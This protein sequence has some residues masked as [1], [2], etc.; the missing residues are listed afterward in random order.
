MKS[1]SEIIK[2]CFE[3]YKH[4]QGMVWTCGLSSLCPLCQFQ[5]NQLNEFEE[6]IN[7][8]I[9]IIG[10]AWENYNV[11][12]VLQELLNKLNGVDNHSH[13][14]KAKLYFTKFNSDFSGSDKQLNNTGDKNENTNT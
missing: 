9:N 11:V 6:M 10:N 12:E 3:V 7:E 13:P 4:E 1:K 2:G 14:E 8:R 5:L